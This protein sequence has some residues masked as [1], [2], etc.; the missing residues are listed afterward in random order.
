MSQQ[1]P[2]SELD[3]AQRKVLERLWAGG[4]TRGLDRVTIIGLHLMGYVD[5]DRLTSAGEELCSK[6]LDEIVARLRNN[7]PEVHRLNCGGVS[8][9][10]PV[11]LSAIVNGAPSPRNK[12]S[13]L[14]I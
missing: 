11:P 10:R 9:K 13:S 2:W 12:K 3:R 5:G 4:S 14:P 1:V 8:L 7:Y 6:A